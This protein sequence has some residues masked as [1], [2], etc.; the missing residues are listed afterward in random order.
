MLVWLTEKLCQMLKSIK[1]FFC[2]HPC[3]LL[4]ELFS[5]NRFGMTKVSL[6]MVSI[7]V[8]KNI[9]K[10]YKKTLSYIFISPPITVK[11]LKEWVLFNNI[12]SS[13]LVCMFALFA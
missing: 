5:Q 11:T 3:E 4:T 6:S 13:P 9:I 10:V 7:K 12:G 2:L 8:Q 1:C